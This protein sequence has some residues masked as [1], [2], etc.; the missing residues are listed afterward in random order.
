M[1]LEIDEGSLEVILGKVMKQQT[2]VLG[3]ECHGICLN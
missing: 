2:A 1:S 3:N